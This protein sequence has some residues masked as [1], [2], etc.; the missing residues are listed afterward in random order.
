MIFNGLYLGDNN[1]ADIASLIENLV[2]DLG[3]GKRELV[4]KLINIQTRKI[5]EILY[6]VN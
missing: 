5:D 1:S 3:G 2:F 6:P 4:N